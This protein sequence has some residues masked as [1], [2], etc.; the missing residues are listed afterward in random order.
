[1]LPEN[2]QGSKLNLYRSTSRKRSCLSYPCPLWP[3]HR[4]KTTHPQ[5]RGTSRSFTLPNQPHKTHKPGS[6][7]HAQF[8][9]FPVL[10]PSIWPRRKRIW[11]QPPC[12]QSYAASAASPSPAR[13][14]TTLSRALSRAAATAGA[15]CKGRAAV[16][17]LKSA[18]AQLRWE[19]WM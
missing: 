5:S 8:Y 2:N 19:R 9:Q 11:P 13:T 6:V 17:R 18:G 16:Q 1:M 4:V 10:R 14:N 3:C 15:R 7:F 12:W